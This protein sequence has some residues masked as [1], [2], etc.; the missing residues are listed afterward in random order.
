MHDSYAQW[1]IPG[2][3]LY[4]GSV[5]P[6]V[7]V[8]TV[9]RHL[10]LNVQ[11]SSPTGIYM[12]QYY[13]FLI[14]APRSMGINTRMQYNGL[15]LIIYP[16]QDTLFVLPTHQSINEDEAVFIGYYKFDGCLFMRDKG[17]D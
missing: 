7:T 8:R 15:P 17:Q 1:V 14:V 11:P 4:T 5:L 13:Y 3:V 9:L 2:T 10:G 6:V 12:T 16:H